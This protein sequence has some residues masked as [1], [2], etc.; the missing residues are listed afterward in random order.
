MRDIIAAAPSGH[1]RFNRSRSLGA[2]SCAAPLGLQFLTPDPPFP[3]HGFAA[4]PSGWA[5]LC[6]ASGAGRAH[7]VQAS[8]LFRCVSV[9]D[10]VGIVEA[11][12]FLAN[13]RRSF[14]E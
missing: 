9:R 13:P 4:T 14:P 3:A 11:Q 2:R 6:R 1:Y 10:T 8:V 12:A 7:V 5:N